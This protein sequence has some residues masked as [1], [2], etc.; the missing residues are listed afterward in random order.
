MSGLVAFCTVG[1]P[2]DAEWI[3]RELVERRLA[4]CVN[5]L[6]QMT[7]VYRWRGEVERNEEILLVIK[8]TR[9]RFEEL[10]QAILSMH[11]YE[12]PEVIGFDIG[13]GHAEY[14]AWLEEAV[15]D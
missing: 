8:T 11:T 10:K 1:K 13:V 6:P 2:E 15:G 14:L 9:A 5:V 12:L 4:A 3:A 7:S